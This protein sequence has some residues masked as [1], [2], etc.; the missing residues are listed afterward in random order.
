MAPPSTR[1][2]RELA[3]RSSDGMDVT[4]VWTQG[5]GRDRED[6]VVVCVCDSRAGAYFEI[7]AE[8][9][10]ALDVYRHPYAYRSLSTVD[11]EDRR[12][13]A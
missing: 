5:D 2:R 13:T 9:C 12:L 6:K 1:P 7:E 4:L 11:Y 8:P 10:L 3:H